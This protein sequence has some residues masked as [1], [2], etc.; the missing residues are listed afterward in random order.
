MHNLS[1]LNEFCLHEVEHL[2]SFD[3][4][5]RGN[6]EMAYSED[7]APA[8]QRYDPV[9]KYKVF[10]LTWPASMQIY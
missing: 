4:E 9:D 7:Q 5:A 3:T 6:S 1:C 8:G 2:T 10:S